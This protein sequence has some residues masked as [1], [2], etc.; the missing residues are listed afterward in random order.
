MAVGHKSAT[1]ASPALRART[2]SGV[3][4]AILDARDSKSAKVSAVA[5]VRNMSEKGTT[6]GGHIDK[7]RHMIGRQKTGEGNPS[8][9]GGKLIG[10]GREDGAML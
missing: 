4:A 6:E 1:T 8:R 9:R 5:G 7:K 3:K 2:I 10:E